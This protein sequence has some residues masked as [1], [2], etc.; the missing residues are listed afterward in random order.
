VTGEVI[1]DV[2]W[3]SVLSQRQLF[4]RGPFPL[5]EP[6]KSPFES[7]TAKRLLDVPAIVLGRRNE[8]GGI[9]GASVE[10]NRKEGMPMNWSRRLT[11][12]RAC[13][14]QAAL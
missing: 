8:G 4:R 13:P 6:G 9:R 14:Q 12:R 5:G 2:A 3:S 1:P 11:A 7:K 10:R